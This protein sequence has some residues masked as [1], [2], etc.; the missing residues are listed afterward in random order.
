MK[1]RGIKI[2]IKMPAPPGG[3]ALKAGQK[4][5]ASFAHHPPA[6]HVE[7]RMERPGKPHPPHN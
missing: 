1:P 5:L 4:M 2:A 7:P 3:R 6:P